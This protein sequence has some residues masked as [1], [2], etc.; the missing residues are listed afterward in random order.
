MALANASVVA[1]TP[2]LVPVWSI[3][4]TSRTRMSSFIRGPA[5]SRS[6]AALIGR[7]MLQSPSVVA[8][9][10]AAKA[11]ERTGHRPAPLRIGE[12]IAQVKIFG[13]KHP[14]PAGWGPRENVVQGRCPA[15]GRR[16]RAYGAAWI[17]R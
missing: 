5:G 4:R 12:I 7:R 17:P 1:T 6:G 9:T 2:T 14:R 16:R 11:V 8:R 10:L 13:G 15:V 3:K